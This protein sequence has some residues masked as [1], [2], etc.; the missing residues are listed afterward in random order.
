MLS[1]HEV[2]NIR[3]NVDTVSKKLHNF[4]FV[5]NN[6]SFFA[7]TRKEA[8]NSDLV[9]LSRMA[10]PNLPESAFS[11]HALEFVSVDVSG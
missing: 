9:S 6:F 2:V 5:L 11:N 7:A 8:L 1:F 4:H 3:D 10:E